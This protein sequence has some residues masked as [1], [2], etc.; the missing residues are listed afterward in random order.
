MDLAAIAPSLPA[1]REDAQ[2]PA[3]T[4]SAASTSPPSAHVPEPTPAEAISQNNQRPPFWGHRVLLVAW[5]LTLVRLPS[6][7]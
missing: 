4:A 7:L 1:D 2:Q 6:L 5:I 3:E